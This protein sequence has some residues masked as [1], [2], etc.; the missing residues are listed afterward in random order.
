MEREGKWQSV[1]P[2]QVKLEIHQMV[3]GVKHKNN[4]HEV[5]TFT[6]SLSQFLYGNYKEN[7]VTTTMPFHEMY[8]SKTVWSFMIIILF[9]TAI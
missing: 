2:R 6:F 5:G 7:S 4:R 8:N 3:A 9:F 1:W